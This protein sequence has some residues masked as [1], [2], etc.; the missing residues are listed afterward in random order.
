MNDIWLT[1]E[2]KDLVIESFRDIFEY[3]NSSGFDPENSRYKTFK[4]FTL[5]LDCMLDF[6]KFLKGELDGN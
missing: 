2:D 6:D 1:Q 5:L 4:A 3:E